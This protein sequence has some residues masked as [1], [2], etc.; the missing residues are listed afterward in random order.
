MPFK[1]LIIHE[2]T[3]EDTT[4]H[5]AQYN[6]AAGDFRLV[7]V[8]VA[9]REFPPTPQTHRWWIMGGGGG[10]IYIYIYVYVH[11]YIHTYILSQ[12]WPS[13]LL[14]GFHQLHPVAVVRRMV[15]DRSRL[16]MNHCASD[17][18]SSIR[19]RH[20]SCAASCAAQAGSSLV[21]KATVRY[22]PG[23]HCEIL[24]FSQLQQVAGLALDDLP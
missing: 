6:N 19:Y 8:S 3:I 15:T 21:L 5:I 16:R 9:P 7:S 2:N 1:D 18:G 14:L 17:A 10:L 22:C 13:T 12:C 11:T 23:T 20:A 4:S 24:C